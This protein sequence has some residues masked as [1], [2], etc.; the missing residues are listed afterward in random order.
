MKFG[1]FDDQNK[2]Y[3]IERP[4]IP[5]PWINYLGNSKYF[6]IISNTAVG[7]L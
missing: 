6:G 4:D 2:E 5:H 1:Y 3:V 7:Y